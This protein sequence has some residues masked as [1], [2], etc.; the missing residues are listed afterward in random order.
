LR[1][2]LSTILRSGLR[3]MATLRSYLPG[4]SGAR[5]ITYH[6]VRPDGPGSRSSYVHPVDFAAQ[7]AW[8]ASSGYQVVPLSQL[9]Q[10]LAAGRPVPGNWACITFDDGYADN[11][12]HAFPVLKAH[13]F[14][15][16][17]FLVT[18]KINRDPLFL[19]YQQME[20]MRSHGIEFG[21]HTV[22]HVSLS[23]LSPDE[24]RQQVVTSK[25]QL[26]AMAGQPALHFCYPFGHYNETVEGFV[27][28]AG[29]QTCC[30]EQAGVVQT[31]ADPFRLRRAGVLGTDTLRDFRLKVQGAY[32]WWI[33]AYMHLEEQRRRRRG[34]LPA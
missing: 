12:V 8:L 2:I 30:T 5:I 26:E 21:A 16:T 32:D 4:P 34:G 20:E 6:S 33:N 9:A 31:G 7:M 19:T 13:R 18:G 17:I 22:D 25:A 1:R 27:R 24:A 10:Q 29:F 14:P 28:T 15:A 3:T 23:S 11:Y